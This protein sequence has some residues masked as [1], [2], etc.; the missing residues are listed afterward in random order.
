MEKSMLSVSAIGKFIEDTFG[1]G[2]DFDGYL[3]AYINPH[4]RNAGEEIVILPRNMAE[5]SDAII[6]CR[7]ADA[8]HNRR[9]N[10]GAY[11][12]DGVA[13][14]TSYS[15]FGSGVLV[16]NNEVVNKVVNILHVGA[17]VWNSI[18][19]KYHC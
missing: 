19:G 17:T 12:T 11:D 15:K 8:E 2:L 9:W 14:R 10:S 6:T 16:S 13:K 7:R 4:A 18:S 3:G 5:D 1:N